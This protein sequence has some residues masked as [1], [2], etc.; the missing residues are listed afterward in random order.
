MA[1]LRS[2]GGPH[3]LEREIH[4]LGIRIPGEGLCQREV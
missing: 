1:E 3:L 2:E 4:A